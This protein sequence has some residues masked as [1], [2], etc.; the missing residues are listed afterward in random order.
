VKGSLRPNTW[1]G[2]VK[3]PNLS[4]W[5]V[6]HLEHQFPLIH[7][8]VGMDKSDARCENL[9]GTTLEVLDPATVALMLLAVQ[10]QNLELNVQYVVRR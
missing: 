2:L 4:A 1:G 9:I 7:N 8:V 10:V 6:S 5:K 3:D